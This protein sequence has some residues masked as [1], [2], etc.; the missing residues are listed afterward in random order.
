VA[1]G[2]DFLR[3]VKSDDYKVVI[4]A[5]KEGR[6]SKADLDRNVRRILKMIVES[7]T[8][9]EAPRPAP[10]YEKNAAIARSSAADGMVLLENRDSILPLMDTVK[11]VAL[12]GEA[13]LKTI[14]GGLGS[15][16]VNCAHITSVAEGLESAGYEI[17][18]DKD[19]AD[20]AIIT[21]SRISGAG[22]DRELTD[23]ILNKEERKLISE[24][25]RVFHS[26][27]KKVIVLLNIGSTIE[28]APWKDEPDAIL[29]IWLPG[30]ESG[31]S[32]ADI[33]TG[34][35]CP[36]GKLPMTFPVGYADAASTANFP[37][38]AKSAYADSVGR[39]VDY[40]LYQEG[41][42]VGYR[43]FDTF[44]KGVVYPFGYGLSYT[45]FTY[46]EPEVIMR[47]RSIKVYVDI[48]NTGTVAGREVAQLYIQAPLGS[49]EKPSKELKGWCKTP[50]LEP[51]EKFTATFTVP[52]RAL[53]SFNESS[54]S[55]TVDA[56]TYIIKV[57]GSSR[58]IVS[59]AA[60]DLDESYQYE[61]NDVLT[62]QQPI[63]E[64]RYRRSIFRERIR[65]ANNDTVKAVKPAA[66]NPN[67]PVPEKLNPYA[68]EPGYVPP[69]DTLKP[70]TD[71][72]ASA[73]AS[74]DSTAGSD[75]I[76]VKETIAA[77][78]DSVAAAATQAASDTTATENKSSRSKKNKR[79][80]IT[81]VLGLF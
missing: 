15:G 7:P 41:I 61:T 62:L 3:P 47:R 1:A 64:L 40:T 22:A 46:D 5:V 36:S 70:A 68:S 20:V 23:Y 6:L 55:W 26:V 78:K 8:F 42:Y 48:I 71:S 14:A 13:S 52:L 72:I 24:T 4:E 10:D 56:G 11:Y 25:C 76:E 81:T 9:A 63:N 29:L 32:V 44:N 39:N 21:I 28:I 12:Y 37:V 77:E 80:D 43:Y 67:G 73:E 53:A 75:P 50:L 31:H 58:D 79:N 49:L 51:G 60:L 57:G 30:Q 19:S 33:L 16:T 38:N 59:E 69:V 45:N 54:A 74:V 2:N 27:G 35:V 17:V 66:F 34:K 65:P 18:A